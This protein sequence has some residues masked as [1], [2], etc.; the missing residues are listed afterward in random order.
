EAPGVGLAAP[1]IG[2]P[3]RLAV[4]EDPAPVPEEVRRVRERE[5]LPYRVL[6]NPV[7]EGVGERRAVFYE[8]CLS[9]P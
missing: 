4:L 8:G 6:I 3:L 1:Q 7:Y 5:P 2:V 9:V